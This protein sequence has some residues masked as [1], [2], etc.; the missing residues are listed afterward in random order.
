MSDLDVRAAVEEMEAWLGDPDWDPE[1]DALDRWNEGFHE[2]LACA[3][4]GEGW[5][6][7]AARCHDLGRRLE[8]RIEHLIQVRNSVKAELDSIGQGNRA[9]KGYG[10]ARI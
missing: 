9:L 10:A 5:P 3:E 7:L 6:D 4:K 2:A 8:G 1:P